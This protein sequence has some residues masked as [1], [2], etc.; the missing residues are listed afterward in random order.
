MTGWAVAVALSAAVAFGWSTALM[1]HGASGAPAARGLRG[2]L[3]HVVRQWRW[4]LGMAASLAG[5]GLHAVALHLGSLVVVQPLVVSGLV[6]AFL[7][8]SA[9]DR[10]D[11]RCLRDQGPPLVGHF[12]VVR[13]KDQN[14]AFFIGKITALH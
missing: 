1:H 9:L 8:R 5:L 12:A 2:L 7:F 4:L 6:F 13:A 11:V 14:D 10:M 3:S